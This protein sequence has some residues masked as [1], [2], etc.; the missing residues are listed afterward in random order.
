MGWILLIFQRA[1]YKLPGTSYPFVLGSDVVGVVDARTTAIIPNNMS[2][3]SAAVVPS[4][5]LTTYQAID[6][7]LQVTSSDG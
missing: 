5:G 7:K 3:M 6:R 1:S 4:A 2:F